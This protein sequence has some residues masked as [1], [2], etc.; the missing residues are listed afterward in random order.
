MHQNYAK[1]GGLEPAA[2]FH[3]DIVALAD[4]VD[5]YRDTGIRP[6]NA[7]HCSEYSSA[8]PKQMVWTMHSSSIHLSQK[9]S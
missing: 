7:Q 3:S 2:T 8:C 9:P 5:V 6:W 1:V 4:V